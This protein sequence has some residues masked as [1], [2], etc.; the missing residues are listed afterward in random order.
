V[1]EAVHKLK[2]EQADPPDA[3]P[4]NWYPYLILHK[5]YLEG[6]SNRVIMSQFYIS[7][8]TFN[9]TRRDAIES[10]ARVLEEMEANLIDFP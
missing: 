9:R 5:A 8:G 7:E 6:I 10:V 3:P 4:R 2:P 1:V